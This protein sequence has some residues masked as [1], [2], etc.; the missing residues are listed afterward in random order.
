MCMR[1][2]LGLSLLLTFNLAHPA[3]AADKLS[4]QAL[5]ARLAAKPTGENA[6][7]LAEDIRAWFGKDRTGKNNVVSGANPR[8]EGLETAWAIEA[9]GAKT[10]AVVTSDGKTL[11][12]TRIGDTPI[13]AA[14]VPFA[15]GSA[16]RWSYSSDGT[17]VARKGQ[18]EV[19]TDQPELA[20][21]PG[22]PKGKL[23]R[24]N[25]WESKIFPNTRRDRWLY[26]PAQYKDDQPACVMVF[27]DGGGYTS[28]VPTVFDNL[29]AKG[30]MPVT[31]AV[32]INPGTGPG[33]GGRG[34]RSVE[35]DTLSDRYARFLL[36]E[37]LP[38][39]EK[40][41]KLRHDPESRAIAGISSGGICAWTVA[42][43]RPDEFRKVL[44]WVGS[45]TNI[46]SGKSR[47][48]GGHNYEALIRK[49]PRKPIRVFLQDGA[50][51][52]DN[53]NG[54]WPLANQQMAKA[55]EFSKY[56]YQFVFG[57]GFHSNRHGRAILPAS[58]RWLW[59]DYKPGDET[60]R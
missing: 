19:Y 23:T 33:E 26:V 50:N 59:R 9:P 44:S 34:Q 60:K 16:F 54:N 37:V 48:D 25:P 42:W 32:F 14:T 45:F 43:E 24:Q 12:L 53:N 22:V 6:E 36:E 15:H 20:E 38:E 29:I 57:Q 51:D 49:T 39:V 21:K 1:A 8:V 28:F 41:V 17:Q 31:V 7:A 18:V 52:L 11:P 56:D 35:Y 58:L 27:Q 5:S 10:A 13:F 3:G 40:S 2:A 30:E 47:H 46:A 4:M 55:L